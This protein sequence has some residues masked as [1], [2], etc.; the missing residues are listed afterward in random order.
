MEAAGYPNGGQPRFRVR[1]LATGIS[2]TS[3]RIGSA[4]TAQFA[5]RFRSAPAPLAARTPRRER[6]IF[7]NLPIQRPCLNLQH[8]PE[9]QR[10]RGS[11]SQERPQTGPARGP[12]C[13]VRKMGSLCVLRAPLQRSSWSSAHYPQVKTLKI[14]FVRCSRLMSKGG[15]PVSDLRTI[16]HRLLSGEAS[17][18]SYSAIS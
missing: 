11:P 9:V 6:R 13:R 15:P 8:P 3:A 5:P 12:S 18:E 1:Q 4:W 17:S 10:A 16:G 7:S 2:R 14:I